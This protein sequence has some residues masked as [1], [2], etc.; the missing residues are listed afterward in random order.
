MLRTI[1]FRFAA[2]HAVLAEPMRREFQPKPSVTQSS[3]R[4]RLSV[5][6]SLDDEAYGTSIREP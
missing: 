5:L 1:A 3:T 2:L 6:G 4:L